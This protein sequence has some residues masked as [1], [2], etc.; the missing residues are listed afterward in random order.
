MLFKIT[1]AGYNYTHDKNFL[2]S[3]PT[4]SQDYLILFFATPVKIKI[5]DEFI[6]TKP[7]S[8]II[9][10]PNYPQWYC[11]EI[12]GLSN[13]FVHFLSNNATEYIKN[14]GLPF[15]IPF[16]INNYSTL[17]VLFKEIETEL[18][19]KDLHWKEQ[20][21]S[22][23]H[24][25]LVNLSR[26]YNRNKEPNLNSYK[27]DLLEKFKVARIDILTKSEHPWTIYEMSDLVNL[28]R[29][30]FTVLYKE[31]FNCTPKEDITNERI[32]KAKH[33]LTNTN[34]SV[35]DVSL[36][37]GYDNIYHFNRQFKKLVGISPGR[38]KFT[39]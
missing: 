3:R 29:S 27:L 37:V 16:Q 25:V 39:C 12:D 10:T 21:N 35:T 20:S 19:M 8:C 36:M 7:N 11:N 28:S 30:R 15:N 23:I 17:R 22:L 24:S 38:Y 14:L 5:D 32:K 26:E 13:D 33:L 4:G 31:F 6:I 1:I 9:Y 18:M 34:L 2:V